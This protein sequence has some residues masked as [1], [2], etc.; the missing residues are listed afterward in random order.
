MAGRGKGRPDNTRGTGVGAGE[1]VWESIGRMGSP[2]RLILGSGRGN[3]GPIACHE[4]HR[5]PDW[6]GNP[7]SGDAVMC[8]G[9]GGLFV[10]FYITAC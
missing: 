5:L 10:V 4:T 3:K 9:L 7:Y 2:G 8:Q 6:F 1:E